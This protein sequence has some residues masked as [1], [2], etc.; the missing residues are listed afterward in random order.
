M[1]DLERFLELY[2]SV[3]IE[4]KPIKTEG[5]D[6]PHYGDQMI[7]IKVPMGRKPTNKVVGWKGFETAVYFDR[8]GNFTCQGVWE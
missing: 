1:T 3:G 7:L 4:L 5:E 6:H 8:A 2:R